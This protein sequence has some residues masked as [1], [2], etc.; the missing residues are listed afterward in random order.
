MPVILWKKAALYLHLH[1]NYESAY[2]STF[3]LRCDLKPFT[4][5]GIGGRDE[6]SSLI[7]PICRDQYMVRLNTDIGWEPDSAY[8]C[9]TWR[10]PRRRS[11]GTVRII[12]IDMILCWFCIHEHVAYMAR[13]C[14]VWTWKRFKWPYVQ[15]NTEW[16][17]QMT[18]LFLIFL[19]L[20]LN[21][22]E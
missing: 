13:C 11:I 10:W 4:T 1:Y 22:E 16:D 17:R 8:K 18:L 20:H 3:P 15:K 9:C 7:F 5:C 14:V 19:Y 2:K 12:L 6:W 21:N